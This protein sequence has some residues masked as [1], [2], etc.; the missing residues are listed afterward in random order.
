MGGLQEWE[1]KEDLQECEG[2]EDLQE[3]AGVGEA[4]SAT[5]SRSACTPGCTASS[6]PSSTLASPPKRLAIGE[7]A[8]AGDA[9]GLLS[10]EK[11]PPKG[12]STVVAGGDGAGIVTGWVGGPEVEATEPSEAVGELAVSGLRMRTLPICTPS[13]S[14]P[15]RSYSESAASL[16]G[17]DRQE[18][19]TMGRR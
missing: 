8:F 7:L 18:R 10:P 1:G 4:V 11:R 5:L 14:Y 15:S 2:K 16:P 13:R 12:L 9:S 3:A 17:W 6:R 19:C